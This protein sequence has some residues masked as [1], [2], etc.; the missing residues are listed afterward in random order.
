SHLLGGPS[1]A[2][3]SGSS[4]QWKAKAA[5]DSEARLDGNQVVLEDQMMKMNDARMNYD[6]ALGLYEK[7][8]SLIQLAIRTPGKGSS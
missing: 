7:S 2:A 8:L 5:P 4:A 1:S 6:T 3:A